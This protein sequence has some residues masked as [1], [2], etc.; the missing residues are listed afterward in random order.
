MSLQP[1]NH[2]P[3]L[4]RL[5]DEGYAVEILHGHL[6]VKHVPY[7]SSQKEIKLGT[8]ISALTLA[9]DV[10]TK[11]GDHTALF[12]GEYPCNQDGHPIEGFR[13][14]SQRMNL[15]AELWADH[16]FSAKP[17]SG[18][19]DDYYHKMTTYI[20]KISG[21]AQ[22]LNPNVTAKIFPVVESKED[23]SVFKYIDT[24]SSRA[25][26]FAITK[27][28]EINKVAVVGLGGTGSYVL[29]LV[30]KT[31][32]REIHLFDG[33]SFLQHNAFRS[34][35]APSVEEL[36]EKLNKAKYFE[37]VYSK[38]RRGIIVHTDFIDA[39]NIAVLREMNF[40]FLCLDQGDAKKMIV[41]DL[42]KASIPFVD[43]GMGL[44]LSEGTLGGI[45]RVTTGTPEYHDH[46]ASKKRI[47]F[48]KDHGNNEYDR[49]IQIADLNALNAVLAVI[50][51]KKLCGF[52]QD[53]EK[54]HFSAYTI[55]GNA[56]INED[57]SGTQS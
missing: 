11:P 6:V 29:D 48:S 17:P 53:F 52:Y 16:R 24:A 13:N 45:L 21:Y 10:T 27:K 15:G 57:Q 55:S 36:R 23:E 39:S 50:K 47:P 1:I 28:L 35:G 51:W 44:Y 14:S 7:V 31:P 33:D 2:S 34:P 49:N 5:R 12:E 8:L 37:R 56:L 54:E 43:V 9:G 40:V 18:N 20:A 26:I 46:L 22:V 42:L 19:Y 41:E 25:E 3:D 38:M 32:V 4:K 30:A